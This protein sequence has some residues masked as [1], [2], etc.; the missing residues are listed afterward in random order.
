M[1]SECITGGEADYCLLGMELNNSAVLELKSKILC[2]TPLAIRDQQPGPFADYTYFPT[3]ACHRADDVIECH[4]SFL[5]Y[6]IGQFFTK[7][8]DPR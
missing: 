6:L 1:V 3:K 7:H 2:S 4:E 5:T 8:N